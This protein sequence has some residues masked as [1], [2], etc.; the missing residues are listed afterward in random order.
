MSPKIF[1]RAGFFSSLIQVSC[2]DIIITDD[3]MVTID[4]NL[5]LIENIPFAEAPKKAMVINLLTADVPHH[6]KLFGTNGTENLRY[7]LI[8]DSLIDAGSIYLIALT[9]NSK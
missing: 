4:E 9:F 8:L 3:T 7:S 1:P 2:H 6:S 5:L